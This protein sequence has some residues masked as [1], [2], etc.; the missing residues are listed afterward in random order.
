MK[1]KPTISASLF[2]VAT[3]LS[4]GTQAAPDPDART[5]KAAARKMKPHSH[6]E[7]KT[8]VPQKAP[9]SGPDRPNPAKD[10]SKHYHPRDG[11]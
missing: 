2:A 9:E 10:M 6:V 3:I 1:L 8:G 4:F 11:K 5:E 7:E